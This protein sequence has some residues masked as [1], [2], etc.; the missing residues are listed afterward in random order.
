MENNNN[1]NQSNQ[2]KIVSSQQTKLLKFTAVSENGMYEKWEI[3]LNPS[4]I[5]SVSRDFRFDLFKP[6]SVV[7]VNGK[8]HTV[9]G[10]T[11]EIIAMI[12]GSSES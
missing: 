8:C 6:A 1:R 3:Y 11:E 9:L 4:H 7:S 10:S 2:E 12:N 5:D